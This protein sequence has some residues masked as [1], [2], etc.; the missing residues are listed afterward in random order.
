MNCT[1][2]AATGLDADIGL[3]VVLAIGLLVAGATLVLVIRRRDRT[4]TAV[5][6]VA[7]IIGAAIAVSPS[8]AAHAARSG[9][10]SPD[11]TLTVIQ[12]SIME[13]LGPGIAPSPIAGSVTNNGQDST[14]I[15]EVRVEIISVTRMPDALPG[16]CDASDYTLLA[17]LMPV[18]RTVASG[19]STTFTG[20]SIGFADKSANQDV[21]KNAVIHLLYTANPR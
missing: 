8:T 15:T 11:N 2:L 18:G 5:L 13:G 1:P 20:A 6:M 17:P 21:C 12:T 9:C 7:V 16:T 19:E 14:Y 10:A 4:M 3:I